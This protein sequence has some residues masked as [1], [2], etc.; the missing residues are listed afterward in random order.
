VCDV[1]NDGKDEFISYT[2]SDITIFGLTATGFE[3]EASLSPSAQNSTAIGIDWV[4]CANFAGDDTFSGLGKHLLAVHIGS[5]NDTNSEI[6]FIEYD[7]IWLTD[8]ND[9]DGQL[10]YPVQYQYTGTDYY[11]AGYVVGTGGSSTSV[12]C[13]PVPFTTP[14]DDVICAFSDGDSVSF[15]DRTLQTTGG[16]RALFPMMTTCVNS[17]AAPCQNEVLPDS[18]TI[19]TVPYTG[20]VGSGFALTISAGGTYYIHSYS[21]SLLRTFV[22]SSGTFS[23]YYTVSGYS[24][25]FQPIR[26]AYRSADIDND[27]DLETCRYGRD[28]LSDERSMLFCM[29]TSGT[30]IIYSLTDTRV[31]NDNRGIGLTFYDIDENGDLEIVYLKWGSTTADSEL[32]F[33][34]TNPSYTYP[35]ISGASVDSGT[36]TGLAIVRNDELDGVFT[37]LFNND[38]V[39]LNHSNS[40]AITQTTYSNIGGLTT[41]GFP[42]FV[43]LN[44][45]LATETVYY[46]AAGTGTIYRHSQLPTTTTITLLNDSVYGGGLFGF[47]SLSCVGDIELKA[48]ECT[49]GLTS[50][51]T[52]TNSLGITSKERVCTTCG[53]TVPL[54]CGSYSYANPSVTCTGVPAGSYTFQAYLETEA[55]PDFSQGV[56]SFAIDVSTDLTCNQDIL[57]QPA[58]YVDPD[59]PTGGGGGTGGVDTRSELEVYYDDWLDTLDESVPAP[60]Q[61]IASI[62][63]MMMFAIYMHTQTNGNNY[64]TV[65]GSLFGAGVSVAL[66]LLAI[67]LVLIIGIGLVV[68]VFIAYKFD[69]M[70]R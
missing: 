60:I 21:D 22:Y 40:S 20:Y 69:S 11:L 14:T 35:A 23:T 64:L 48:I 9:N 17:N 50:S 18:K 7:P 53:G 41:G 29:D 5:G 37:I 67:E 2:T 44:N 15:L 45:D 24:T 16:K 26:G 30:N 3:T 51:C 57:S 68:F 55:Q 47:D 61:L 63:I 12:S 52:Y 65:I 42:F 4:V 59:D 36:P 32:I 49:S 8:D 70:G 27:G 43:D 28:S 31:A 62:V 58:T 1:D 46:Y 34:L 25:S 33:G 10:D 66:G 6:Q 54:K 19:T 38:V 56:V 13:S 39:L